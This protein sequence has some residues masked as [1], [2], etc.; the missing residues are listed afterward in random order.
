MEKNNMILPSLKDA[1]QRTKKDIYR[2]DFVMPTDL[3]DLGVNKRYY[4]RTYGCQ[5]N[6]RDSETIA[7]ILDDMSF[8]RTYDYNEADIL[9]FN[10]C[11]IR[12]NA[13]NKVFGEIGQLKRLKQIN[14]DVIFAVCGCMVQEEVVVNRILEKYDQIDLIFGTHNIYR[15]PELIRNVYFS[16]ERV[17]EVF[18]NEGGV[19]EALPVKRFNEYKA[20]VNI[21]YGCDKFCTYCIVPYT[22]GKQR[23]RELDDILEEVKDLKSKGYKEVTLLGQNVNAYG[24]DLNMDDGFTILLESVARVGIDRVRFATSHPRD[25]SKS[26][27]DVMKKY[28]NIM[29][30]LHLPVQSGNNEVLRM[31]GRG[32]SVEHYKEIYDELKKAIPNLAFS[33]DMIVGFPNESEEQFLDTLELVDYCKF[34]FAFLFIYSKREGTP[35]SKME[36]N[37]SEEE[38]NLRLKR[39]NERVAKYTKLNNSKYLNKVVKV[40]VDGPSKKNKDVFSGYSEENKL[41]NFTGENIKQG[42]IVNVL[43]TDIKSWSMNGIK[44]EDNNG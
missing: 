28:D 33:T 8:K 32:Y 10:T 43:I 30:Y 20:W 7:G 31:M 18:S 11:A 26:L 17:V 23:S 38:K 25:F 42:D 44:L 9:F 36:D 29:P 1:K 39:L 24:K 6:E 35:A 40:L 37:I 12:E 34:D 5:A 2:E 41:V 14:P 21:M 4:I 3:K 19:I 13:E 16:K 22:R 27:I 15:L